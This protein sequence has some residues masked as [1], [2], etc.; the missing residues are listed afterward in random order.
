MGVIQLK[1]DKYIEQHRLTRQE[2]ADRI[3][4]HR[5]S[6]YNLDDDSIK[7]GTLRKISDVMGITIT[8]FFEEP[9][10]DLT[11]KK[12]HEMAETLMNMARELNPSYE[13]KEIKKPTKSD[14]QTKKTK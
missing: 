8:S 9:K 4:I 11:E 14:K 12:K 3:G 13:K 7:L 2:F 5:D 10:A 1:V 6:T